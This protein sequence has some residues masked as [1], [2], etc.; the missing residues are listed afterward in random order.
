[1]TLDSFVPAH[2][3]LDWLDKA[4]G[5]LRRDEGILP[6]P[7][8]GSVLGGIRQLAAPRVDESFVVAPAGAVQAELAIVNAAPGEYALILDQVHFT[9]SQAALSPDSLQQWEGPAGDLRPVRWTRTG[10]RVEEVDTANHGVGSVLLGDGPE[11]TVLSQVVDVQPGQSYELRVRAWSFPA[12]KPGTGPPPAAP[13]ARL[14]LRWGGAGADPVVVPLDA[15]GFAGHAWAGLVP[16]GATTAEIR[17]VE[18]RGAA[19]LLV[20]SVSFSPV[21]AVAVPLIFLAEAPGELTIS[22]LHITYDSPEAE[23]PSL[24]AAEFG[25]AGSTRH[26]ALA[27]VAPSPLAPAT[28]PAPAPPPE[29]ALTDVSGIGERRA[30]LLASQGIETIA[31]L[32]AASPSDIAR[33]FRGVSLESATLMV[34]DAKRKLSPA[35]RPSRPLP[36]PRLGL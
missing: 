11:D 9:P 14:E 22:D 7:Q 18:P 24:R 30:R 15:S 32:A 8:F 23:E 27:T 5:S 25:L 3:E 34:E 29:P 6:F 12:A 19:P 10:G 33:L 36:D 28:P 4:G 21:E 31:D 26:L 17:I 16:S 35:E 20:E 2:W 1:L 13:G